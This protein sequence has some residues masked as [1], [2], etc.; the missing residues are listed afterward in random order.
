VASDADAEASAMRNAEAEV[1]DDV[2][3]L[4]EAETMV[5]ALAETEDDTADVAAP[6]VVSGTP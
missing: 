2:A 5:T 6:C 4:A 3:V 1:V